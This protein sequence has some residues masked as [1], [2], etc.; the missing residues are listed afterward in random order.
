MYE[1]ARSIAG[2][3]PKILGAL[4]QT[5]GLAGQPDKARALLRSLQ[6]LSERQYVGNSTFALIHLGLGELDL[7]VAR[8]QHAVNSHE[9]SATGLNIHPAWDALRPDPRFQMLL[10]QVGLV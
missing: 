2:D 6:A 10:K 5:L 4:G 8:L 1:T 9:L 3:F 7:A